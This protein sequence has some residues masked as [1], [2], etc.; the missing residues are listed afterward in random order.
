M[1]SWQTIYYYKTG[2]ICLNSILEMPSTLSVKSLLVVG[3]HA[4]THACTHAGTHAR[5][6]ACT[7]AHFR[8]FS[9]QD[10]YSSYRWFK[11]AAYRH[12]V[13]GLLTNIVWTLIDSLD[14]VYR[15]G[16]E[17]FSNW[18]KI[19]LR[20]SWVGGGRGG[21][22]RILGCLGRPT[23]PPGGHAGSENDTLPKL[24]ESCLII[25]SSGRFCFS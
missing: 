24:H 1:L 10:D 21:G 11:S 5:M 9:T 15:D 22:R 4:R 13:I 12:C 14:D 16:V 17:V 18:K 8:F 7:H 3:L 25:L 6:H 2:L 20:S 23:P 19:S